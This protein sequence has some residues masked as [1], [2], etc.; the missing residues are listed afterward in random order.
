MVITG[1]PL[2]IQEV[3]AYFLQ[4]LLIVVLQSVIA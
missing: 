2:I 1:S 4:D 3:D